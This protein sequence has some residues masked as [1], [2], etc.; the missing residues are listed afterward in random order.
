MAGGEGVMYYFARPIQL[1][2]KYVIQLIP[3]SEF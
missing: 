2:N 3:I 1:T